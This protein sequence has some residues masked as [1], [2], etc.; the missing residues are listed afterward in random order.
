M[1]NPF[2]PVASTRG[3]AWRIAAAALVLVVATVAA[4]VLSKGGAAEVDPMAGMDMGGIVTEPGGPK[5]VTLTAAQAARI[6]VTYATVTRQGV[7]RDI[8]AVGLVTADESRVQTLSLKVDGWV[9]SLAVNV[10]GQQVARGAPLLELYSPMLVAA[11]EELL[12]ARR[13]VDGVAGSDAAARAS[14][15]DLLSSARERLAYW[16]VPAAEIAAIERDGRV[17]RT[18]TILSRGSGHVLEKRVVDGQRVMAGDALF[19]IADLESVWV[20]TEVFA[21]DLAAVRV[22]QTVEV[23]FEAFAGE[24]RRARITF[25]QPTVDPQSRT[26]RVRAEL[27]NKDRRLLPG[28]YATIRFSIAPSGNTLSVPRSAVLATG[29]R[30]LVFVREADGS[31]SPRAVRLGSSSDDR[32]EVLSGLKEGDVVVASAT[33]LVDAESSLRALKP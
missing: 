13:L 27:S 2:D 26:V 14:A 33:F 32:V 19:L 18:I 8:R 5:S 23:G 3:R 24:S 15:A 1:T 16:D 9:E 12:L 10:T 29:D 31:L 4:I 28:M 11:Q 25:I 7:T 20:E 21:Q 6:G 22:G 17:R 30:A